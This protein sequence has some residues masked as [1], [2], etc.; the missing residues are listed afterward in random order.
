MPLTEA[1]RPWLALISTLL[2]YQGLCAPDLFFPIN[3]QVP[4]VAYVSRLYQFTFSRATFVS[5]ATQISYSISRSP[6]WLQLNSSTRTLSGIPTQEDV[7]S[8]TV[9][10][11]AEDVSGRSTTFVTLV[12]LETTELSMGDSILSRLIELGPVSPPNTL[13]FHP[14]EPFILTFQKRLFSGTSSHT[15]YYATSTDRSPLPSWIQFNADEVGYTGTAPSLASVRAS[16][17]TYGILLIASNVP[18]FAEV[19]VAFQITIGLHV[20]SCRNPSSTLVTKVGAFFQ[21][22]PLRDMLLLDGLPIF[23]SQIASVTLLDAPAW[24]QLDESLIVLRGTSPTLFNTSITATAT[25]VYGDTT[26]ITWS[27]EF[28]KSSLVSLEVLAE[29]NVTTGCYFEISLEVSDTWDFVDI[30]TTPEWV[31]F[32]ATSRTLYGN[33][34]KNARPAKFSIS[35]LLANTTTK[36]TSAILIDVRPDEDSASPSATSTSESIVP[37]SPRPIPGVSA[38]PTP[39]CASHGTR[40]GILRLALGIGLSCVAVLVVVLFFTFCFRKRRKLLAAKSMPTSSTT[41]EL[42]LNDGDLPKPSIRADRLGSES[43]SPSDAGF[44]AMENSLRVEAQRQ[45]C[46]VHHV[47]RRQEG[48][49]AFPNR[50]SLQ[51]ATTKPAGNKIGYL[52]YIN[53]PPLNTPNRKT[54]EEYQRSKPHPSSDWLNIHRTARD[55]VG[56]ED[57]LECFTPSLNTRVRPRSVFAGSGLFEPGYS[58]DTHGDDDDLSSGDGRCERVSVRAMRHLQ[59]PASRIIPLAHSGQI[60]LFDRRNHVSIQE[61]SLHRSQRSQNGCISMDKI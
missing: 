52:S 24:A 12:V 42:I 58:H 17:Q 14:L 38:H 47:Q 1:R 34:P 59:N 23:D 39:G 18:G 32:N 46:Y 44:E 6:D 3:S 4:P 61:G 35:V 8:A 13:L 11:T 31:H 28:V 27:L 55:A 51:R 16:P 21:T 5:T 50:G 48:R 9:V 30:H 57:P 15:R 43:I 56:S 26:N 37:S 33:V 7:G 41:N 45:Q 10:L 29:I 40:E 53:R 60:Q 22:T 19:T 49:A 20:L 54:F 36:A 2:A 25:D